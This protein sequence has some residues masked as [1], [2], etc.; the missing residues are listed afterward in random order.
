MKRIFLAFVASVIITQDVSYADYA[1]GFKAGYESNSGGGFFGGLFEGINTGL[2]RRRIAEEREQNSNYLS[3][4]K[5]IVV[6]ERN[7]KCAI[8]Y[9]LGYL[10]VEW[11]SGYPPYEGDIYAGDFLG[12]GMKELYCLNRD[13]TTRFWVEDYMAS[14]DKAREFLYK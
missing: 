6:K 4:S 1:E 2:E 13:R 9:S 12:Y 14:A 10:L 8:E 7:G 5:G 3:S 11:Y